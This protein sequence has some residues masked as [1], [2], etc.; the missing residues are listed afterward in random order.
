MYIMSFWLHSCSVMAKQVLLCLF[1]FGKLGLKWMNWFALVHKIVKWPYVRNSRL[2]I[3]SVKLIRTESQLFK[4]IQ[5]S[6]TKMWRTNRVNQETYAFKK[7]DLKRLLNLQL[8]NEGRGRGFNYLWS[9]NLS[10]FCC[11]VS[12]GICWGWERRGNLCP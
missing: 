8:Q 5:L 2:L 6:K 9:E 4:V 11:P 10:D 7:R 3:W 1:S 12:Q